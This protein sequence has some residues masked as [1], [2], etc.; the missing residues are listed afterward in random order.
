MLP[1]HL[2]MA[3]T[4]RLAPSFCHPNPTTKIGSKMGGKFTFRVYK[5]SREKFDLGTWSWHGEF[6]PQ[7]RLGPGLAGNQPV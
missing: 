6:G 4:N 5:L 1:R 7:N 3:Q 2:A